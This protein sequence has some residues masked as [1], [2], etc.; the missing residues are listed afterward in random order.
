MKKLIS[1]I[2]VL[3]MVLALAACGSS[4]PA[5]ATEA[6]AAST[7]APAEDVSAD[8]TFV[9]GI[10]QLVQHPALDAATQGF[11]DALT[12]A[13]GDKVTFQEQNASGDSATCSLICNQFVSDEVDLIMA[14]A[15]ASI[16]A[17]ASAT[18]TIPILGTSIT[19]YGVALGV[20]NWTGVS[21]T[22]ISGTSDL[23]PLDGQAAMVQELFPD[24]K[25]SGL[26]DS[27]EALLTDMGYSVERYTF[28]DSNDV[29]SVTANACS[30]SDVLYIPTDNTAAS[31]TEAINNVALS[32]GIPIV[33]GEEGL[34][35]GCGV[36]TLSI[37]Y[38]DLGRATGEM[39]AEILTEG[40]D[41]STMEVRFAPAFTKEYNADICEALNITVPEDY[42]AIA[43]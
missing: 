4:A 15:T 40:A 12:E 35:S 9:V 11:K 30:N 41:V 6:P 1:L 38:Y 20:D 14:N 8:K 27:M 7:E 28:A 26:L 5:A 10:C 32:A 18:N 17:A 25:T 3:A 16:Q 31:C 42:I 33:A 34:A 23:A 29:S 22:N 39:A 37:S 19:D 24:A 36:A 13:L 21:G 2:C 43:K